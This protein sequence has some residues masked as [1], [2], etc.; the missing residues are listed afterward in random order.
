MTALDLPHEA[1]SFFS[2]DGYRCQIGNHP[3]LI[4]VALIF[5]IYGASSHPR[6]DSVAKRGSTN[7]R[8]EFV[9]E[10]VANCRV[11]SN[12]SLEPLDRCECGLFSTV[13]DKEIRFREDNDPLVIK[14]GFR[15]GNF[16]LEEILDLKESFTS[17][18]DNLLDGV[19]LVRGQVIIE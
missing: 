8:K 12:Q 4:T 15:R 10:F 18:M 13:H 5:S 2:M 14:L 7:S 19:G 6:W 17:T 3:E 16:T 11:E 1:N 9:T